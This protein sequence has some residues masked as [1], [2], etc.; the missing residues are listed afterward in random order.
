MAKRYVCEGCNK[1]CRYGV[2][3]TCEQTPSGCML[4]PPSLS[5]G[6]RISCDLCNR[7]FRSQTCYDN[8]KKKIQGKRQKKS[9]CELRKFCGTCGG[10]ITHTKHECNKR[11]FATCYE[12]KEVGHLSFM[13]P[14]V[15]VPASSEHMLYVFYDFETTQRRIRNALISDTSLYRI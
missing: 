2:E 13:R 12:N 8:H 10:L 9:A 4:S 14:L 11:F 7:Q 6:P 5:S 15:N 1:G 3:H